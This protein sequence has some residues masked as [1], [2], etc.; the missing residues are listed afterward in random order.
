M[1]R[2]YM[3]YNSYAG[4]NFNIVVEFARDIAKKGQPKASKIL[5]FLIDKP[6]RDYINLCFAYLRWAD[7]IVDN[8]NLPVSQ[9]RKFIEHQR[10]L[11]SLIYEKK[12]FEPSGI[13]E[14]CFLH[15]SEYVTSTNNLLLVDEVKNMI[16][17]LSMDVDRLEANG[18][19]TNAELDHY[20][21]L[22][23]KSFF[24]ILCFFSIPKTKYRK[25]FYLGAK[26]TTIALMIKDLEEDI[27][28][29]FINIPAEDIDHYM[30]DVKNLK[31]DE[32]FSLY[33]AERIKFIFRILYQEVS[34]LKYLPMKFRIFTYYSLIYRMVWVVRAKVYGYNLKYISDQTFF[35][36]LKTYLVSF[37]ISLNIFFKGFIFP[38]RI[39]E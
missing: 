19:F 18:V 30:L 2:F 27:D 23:S 33:L 13:E 21:E 38:H 16:D 11:I 12:I 22:M 10:N 8:P 4:F 20:I 6:E 35:K 26:F 36:E 1:G 7:D 15:Y 17:A 5:D 31:K 9:K 29:G 32:N 14:A 28:A 39:E 24:N 3:N 25:E 37:F 34:L